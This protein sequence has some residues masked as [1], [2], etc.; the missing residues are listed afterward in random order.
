MKEKK[1]V[2]FWKKLKR[3]VIFVF[4]LMLI[5]AFM[6]QK[7]ELQEARDKVSRLSAAQTE[8]TEPKPA[9][10]RAPTT[11][12]TEKETEPEAETKEPE[13][14]PPTTKAPETEPPTTVPATTARTG[15]R[16]AFKAAMDSYE[17]FYDEYVEFLKQYKKNPTDLGLLG[18]YAQMLEKLEDMDKKF[19]AW[20]DD[21]LND[22]ELKYWLQVQTRIQQ[23]LIDI[24]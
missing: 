18:K 24:L 15:L 10:T 9:P 6:E 23:K 7:S 20:K 8:T 3:L 21:D 12:P 17:A 13:T 14:E 16:P 19:E 1:K 5:Y 4:A 22:E 2:G 11:A